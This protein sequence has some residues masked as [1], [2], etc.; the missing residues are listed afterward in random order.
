VNPPIKIEE[1]FKKYPDSIMT[2]EAKS[3]GY[4]YNFDVAE[5]DVMYGLEQDDFRYRN[6][7]IK[8]HNK[9]PKDMVLV[10]IDFVDK[11]GNKMID[12]FLAFITAKYY[13][14]L[15]S[16]YRTTIPF[17]SARHDS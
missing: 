3:P 2:L 1:I 16:N 9:M 13:D 4:N 12:A 15:L 7:K 10:D 11:M 14:W 5:K 6:V 17:N 8:L